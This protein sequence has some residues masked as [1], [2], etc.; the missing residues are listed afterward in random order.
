MSFAENK[1]KTWK[2]TDVSVRLSAAYC[3]IIAV[4]PVMADRIGLKPGE[5]AKVLH[6]T[7]EDLWKMRVVPCGQ[8]GG[9]VVQA[10]GG[11]G[12]ALRIAF[13]R[14]SDFPAFAPFTPK[15]TELPGG[16]IELDYRSE[17]RRLEIQDQ[18]DHGRVVNFQ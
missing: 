10:P 14:P 11:N 7:G 17:K 2:M 6:G 12:K 4:G 5:R 1:P 16:G 18:R 13:R 9:Y 15:L 8:D 3:V